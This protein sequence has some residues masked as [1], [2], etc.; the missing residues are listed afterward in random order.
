[1]FQLLW[2][3]I[4]KPALVCAVLAL[5][6]QL[7]DPRWI[8]FV[9]ALAL[10]LLNSRIGRAVSESVQDAFVSLGTMVRAGLIPGLIR[11]TL[12]VFKQIV[13]SIEYALFVVDEW[14]RYRSGGSRTS[15][16]VR[17][18]LGVIW[19]PISFL[20]RF[21]MVVLIE[22]CLNPLKLPISILAAKFVYPLLA[23]WGLFEPATLSS[24][25]VPQPPPYLLFA[26][27]WVVVIGTFYFL[28]DAFA[29]LAWELKE[30][31][32][33]YRANRGSVL[34]PVGIGAHG[35]TLRGLLQPGF[36]SG[37][38]P[39]I[40]ARL[41]LAEH[42]ATRTRN[43]QTVRAYH[44]EVKAVAETV[45]HFASREMVA[46][47]NQSRSLQGRHV[48]VAQVHLATN[49]VGI[50]LSH[51]DHP[52]QPVEI[53]I[54]YRNGWL[55]AGVRDTGWLEKTNEDQRR[56]FCVCL[57]GLYKRADV[58]LVREQI[59]A[60]LPGPVVA[61]Q[62]SYEGLQVWT[63]PHSEPRYYPLRESQDDPRSAE[64]VK[65]LV[66]GR[67]PIPWQQWV[68]WWEK[69]QDGK[70]QPGLPALSESL[71]RLQPR[72]SER[73]ERDGEPGASATGAVLGEPGASATG[74]VLGEPGT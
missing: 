25:L 61:F 2:W 8:G 70:G 39:R 9:F 35:E 24:P 1:V 13:E 19:Y 62:V 23:V 33:L 10:F 3:Y 73:H 56:A 69:D 67:V 64:E 47:L 68:E 36:H 22:P 17:T 71:I 27:S 58:D 43:W 60:T 59:Q 7:H 29:F 72:A 18:L 15:L 34:Q 28:P 12:Q 55:V 54:E 37:T 66:F 65:H 52:S 40:Y 53:E 74:A 21:Y 6:F 45:R 42:K 44:H 5:A 49:R 11:F 16:V 50:E 51:A 20:A 38:I 14:L 41:R 63:D 48:A 4:L 46:L 31:W 57:A 26:V 32:N 30:N